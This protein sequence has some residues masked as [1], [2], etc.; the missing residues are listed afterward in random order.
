LNGFK[1][2]ILNGISSWFLVG[3]KHIWRILTSNH[4][5]NVVLH[6]IAK[7]VYNYNTL[8]F[9]VHI[10]TDIW[11]GYTGILF[12]LYVYYINYIVTIECFI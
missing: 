2:V 10:V 4:I 12:M 8:G 5:Y 6:W 9:K 1:M 3:L 7:L 11:Q